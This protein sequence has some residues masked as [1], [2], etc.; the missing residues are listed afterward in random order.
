MEQAS[1]ALGTL[2]KIFFSFSG[3][4]FSRAQ[5]ELYSELKSVETI[6]Q[7]LT[8]RLTQDNRV[9]KELDS[10]LSVLAT[11]LELYSGDQIWP[12]SSDQQREIL[13]KLA[14]LKSSLLTPEENDERAV[15]EGSVN[16]APGPDTVQ[17]NVKKSTF[18]NVRGS[19]LSNNSIHFNADPAVRDG[20]DRLVDKAA[21]A[22]RDKKRIAFLDWISTLDFHTTQRETFAKRAEGTGNW[23]IQ[24]PRFLRWLSGALKVLWCSGNPG[25][26]KTILSSLIVDHLRSIM[27]PD[28]AVAYIYCD[29]N[30]ETEQTSSQLLSSI[31]KQVVEMRETISDELLALHKTCL[32]QKTHP[33]IP[34]LMTALHREIQSYSHVYIII[35]GLDECSEAAR[36]LFLSNKADGGL[37]SLSGM[38]G[39]L[40]TSRNIHSIAQELK[41]ET[42]IDINAHNADLQ[43]YIR[44]RIIGD[45]RLKRLVKGDTTLETD[46]IDQVIK[47]AAG[48]FLQARL[49]LD[50]L[51][52]QLN[53]K[54]LRA[55]LSTLPEAIMNSYDS[56]MVRINAQGKA[57]CELAYQVFYW[58]TY[59]KR[60]LKVE[61]LQHALAVA[62]DPDM[63]VMD[64][65]AIVDVE[66]LTG[67]CAGLVVISNDSRKNSI[68]RLVHYTTREYFESK[69][70]HL[71]PDI[72]SAIAITCMTYLSFN[73]FRRT[74]TW[75]SAR[76]D[77]FYDYAARYWI[78]HTREDEKKAAQHVLK[79][80]EKAE[81]FE[82][83]AHHQSWFIDWPNPP[84][85]YHF[86]ARHGLHLTLATLVPAKNSIS[87]DCI[88]N[89]SGKTAVLFAAEYGHVKAV[90]VLLNIG[91]DPNL[92]VD[93]RGM[94][95]K[96]RDLS[97]AVDTTPFHYEQQITLLQRAITIDNVEVARLLL[98]HPNIQPNL[99]AD[100]ISGWTPLHHAVEY[101]HVK[102]IELLFQHTDIQINLADSLGKTPLHYAVDK[103]IVQIIRILLLRADLQP[104]LADNAG[105]TP[106]HYAASYNNGDVVQLLLQLKNIQPK[107]V[108]NNGD[109][110]LTLACRQGYIEAIKPFLQRVDVDIESYD[111]HSSTPLSCALEYG[112][113][114]VTGLLLQHQFI[115]TGRIPLNYDADKHP[116][117]FHL[118]DL[119]LQQSA[120]PSTSDDPVG[121]HT[122]NLHIEL[123]RSLLR[124]HNV[125][126]HHA[127]GQ[128]HVATMKLLLQ[129]DEID[130]NFQDDQ[131]RTALSYAVE[132][133]HME[134]VWFLLQ[135]HNTQSDLADKDRR[136]PLMYCWSEE[137][138]AIFKL[139]LR[140]K[141]INLNATDILGCTPLTY[142]A[143]N[144]LQ[145]MA[146]LLLAKDAAPDPKDIYLRTPLSY[147]AAAGHGRM[148]K[149]LL[150][151]T[152][153]DPW[154]TDIYSHT[155]LFYAQESFKKF[156]LPNFGKTVELLAQRGS[157][158]RFI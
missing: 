158:V 23:F 55:A 135:L 26:G 41:A 21:D 114:E 28:V 75:P 9:L 105:Q 31:L 68:M 120:M 133:C 80:M 37:C 140:C 97:A 100:S 50:S 143:C 86:L 32:S 46:I 39:L 3:S 145:T 132:G 139:L 137:H 59:A 10:E 156:P 149:L 150:A 108:D 157:Y 96:F 33:T 47:K 16:Q 122:P 144:G 1:D 115:Q 57:E 79:F 109:T 27:T 88:D 129:T 81:N 17:L 4:H 85:P 148:V 74:M 56:A 77:P 44:G 34:E 49:H 76:Q 126:W 15:L 99:A 103:N 7:L 155:P 45:N 138:L 70:L 78:D 111:C 119:I 25:V 30:R 67:V 102:I 123:V 117:N 106:L 112:H 153:V 53:R 24:D 82:N 87:F 51:S 60:P 94:P 14:R 38:V 118:I 36:D 121:L 13:A 43:G 54:A 8:H 11:A 71:F 91:A 146:Q 5:L 42:R 29:Y 83:A 64:P 127:A 2:V 125:T 40:F 69:Q 113:L 110:A 20:V 90:A 107:L 84:K 52:S 152:D 72:H 61:E 131:S 65:D 89:D 124:V 136:T 62:S 22:E 95:L 134:V 151:Q 101:N 116:L 104:N 18:R 19:V 73:V 130:P 35:D 93:I 92:V 154:S 147:A 48:K 12:F 142:A 66:F 63:F 58:L 6:I 141:E 128:G 98:Q